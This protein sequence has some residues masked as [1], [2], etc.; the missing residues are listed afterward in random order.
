LPTRFHWGVPQP[1]DPVAC[2]A[3]AWPRVG[4]IPKMTS[5]EQ[6]VTMLT[7]SLGIAAL[8]SALWWSLDGRWMMHAN[9]PSVAAWALWALVAALALA[10]HELIHYALLPRAI[11]ERGFGLCW[12]GAF[13]AVEGCMSRNRCL[14]VLLAPL[15]LLTGG[16]LLWR[17]FI[18]PVNDWIITAS[19]WNGAGSI[20]DLIVSARLLAAVPRDATLHLGTGDLRYAA[21]EPRALPHT[22]HSPIRVQAPRASAS[23]RVSVKLHPRLRAPERVEHDAQRT[24]L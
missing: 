21:P 18:G 5:A 4:G 1:L 3:Q 6:I 8:T 11:S 22:R 16:P 2:G 7:A 9:T 23:R 20:V 13:V 19:I 15:L 24:V 10:L 14:L 12:W 17:L